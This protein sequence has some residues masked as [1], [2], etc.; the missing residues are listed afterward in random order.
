MV[1]G[2]CP[3]VDFAFKCLFGSPEHAAVT[4]HFLNSI[5]VSG[6]KI[7]RVEFR[8]PF[9]EK[10]AEDDKLAVL[11]ILATDEHDRRLNIEMQTTLPVGM[12]KR[13]AYYASRLYYDQ[14]FEGE[15]YSDLRPAISICVLTKALFPT[16]PELHLDFRL[17]AASGQLLT[18]DLQIH[19][20]ELPKLRVTVK[21]VRQAS[22]IEQ[23][24]F[25]L[26]NAQNLTRHDVA[27]LFPDHEFSEAAGVLQ[28]IARTP[29]QL[30]LYDARLKFQRD[31]AAKLEGARLEGKQEGKEEGREEGREE[32]EKKGL[33]KGELL[34]R[35]LVLR[36]LLEVQPLTRAELAAFSE[37]ELS[38]MADDLQ[39]QLRHRGQ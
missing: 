23:W 3:T 34:G 19:L 32:G 2:I 24:G 27:R 18:D 4:V 38:A 31:E 11:D 5:L 30:A 13:L 1:I 15:Q 8:H 35:I 10:T 16:C 12:S 7:S 29:E 39:S 20:L 25:F 9:L 17:R 26:Q 6:P 21:N 14:L 28:M 22:P 36:E 37:D 33:R